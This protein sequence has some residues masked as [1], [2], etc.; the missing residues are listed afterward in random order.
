MFFLI[1]VFFVGVLKKKIKNNK[2][3]KNLIQKRLKKIIYTSPIIYTKK[4]KIMEINEKKRRP[5]IDLLYQPVTKR[6]KNVKTIFNIV[7]IIDSVSIISSS[8]N[9]K[10][11][12]NQINL[13]LNGFYYVNLFIVLLNDD[14]YIQQPHDIQKIYNTE[15]ILVGHI[16]DNP[17]SSN[18]NMDIVCENMETTHVVARGYSM[19]H[20]NILYN[21]NGYLFENRCNLTFVG[22]DNVSTG[23]ASDLQKQYKDSKYVYFNIGHFQTCNNYLDKL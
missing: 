10:Q 21:L 23:L 17:I 9:L 13:Y 4:D 6:N 7:L 12:I 3:K 20:P 1:G 14:H 22:F 2:Y 15:Y 8:D 16:I 11:L 19:I 18:N 5:E